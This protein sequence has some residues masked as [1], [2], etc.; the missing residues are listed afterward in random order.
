[1]E[2]KCGAIWSSA[3]AR[4]EESEMIAHLKSMFW[5]SS[6]VDGNLY[7]PDSSVNSCVTTSTMP[8]SLFLPLMDYEGY[9]SVPL[10]ASTGMDICSD[11]QHQVVATRNKAMSGSKRIFPMDE[12]FEQQQQKKP[13]KKTRPGR[14]VSSTLSSDITDSET[15]SELVNSTY[16]SGCSFGEDSVATTD[17]SIVLKQNGN[18]RGHKKSSKDTQSLY[19]KRRR[20]RIN[21]RLRILQQL[22][23]NG[24]KVDISTMLEEAVQ[25]VKFLQLQIKLLS[26][27][28][29]WMFAP[30]AYDGMSMGL[31]Q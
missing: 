26:S 13:Q 4:S 15:S 27:D 7:S 31:N 2:A 11:H 3:D 10:M 30:L 12:H 17:E 29:T 16:S 9:G 20:E 18:L 19:A 22:I 5:G 14:S 6:D 8:C 23:P 25:Y 28:D 1:M 21:E 24:T